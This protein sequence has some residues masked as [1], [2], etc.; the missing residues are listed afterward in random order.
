MYIPQS[1][2]RI[3]YEWTCS[4][5]T[6][7]RGGKLKLERYEKLDSLGFKWTLNNMQLKLDLMWEARYAELEAYKQ[8]HGHMQVPSVSFCLMANLFYFF[9]INQILTHMY[10]DTVGPTRSV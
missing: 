8:K 7:H 6:A 3:L 5:R 2:G 10:T 1:Q 4:Q 9:I